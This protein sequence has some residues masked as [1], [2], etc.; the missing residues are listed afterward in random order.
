MVFCIHDYE[1]KEGKIMEKMQNKQK[2]W[3]VVLTVYLVCFVFRLLEYFVLRTDKTVFGEA[4]VHKILGI[5][6]LF[7]AIRTLQI[8]G[9][10][11]G[12]CRKHFGNNVIKGL[13]FG[14]A[15]FV[16]AYGAEVVLQMIKGNFDSL[17]VYVSTYAVDGNVGNRTAWIFFL[18][19]IL[20]NVI[21]VVMEEGI[22]RGLFGKV[23]ER[24]YSFIVSAFFASILFGV[25]HVVGPVRNYFDGTMSMGG[26]IANSLMLVGTSAL[27]GF[28]FA[29]LTKMTGNLA[30]A[31]GD[32][33]VNNTIVNL[34]HVVSKTGAD[35][36]MTVRLTIA[37]SVS[38]V[39]V[40]V[41]Y[42]V[43]CH[44]KE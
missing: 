43:K 36:L 10:E 30:M 28:K 12:L 17:Q 35:E 41:Y 23:L 7:L 1:D 31:M 44:K 13:G 9:S 25:W 18:I 26:M 40:L 34:L 5:G 3:S 39:M 38:C 8:R 33:F 16:L 2:V 20:G 27:V 22:F 11:I 42:L 4:V 24:K 29:L 19:C 6:V 37:Q 21:N 15:T 14:I 32:H